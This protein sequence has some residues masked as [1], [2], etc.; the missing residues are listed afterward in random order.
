VAAVFA[1]A[2]ENVNA[3]RL[4]LYASL[5]AVGL[6]VFAY[7][8][9]VLS[10][11][12]AGVVAA[13]TVTAL[14]ARHAP[15]TILA[16]L[17]FM[18]AFWLTCVVAERAG[19]TWLDWGVLAVAGA[20]AFSFRMAALP[21][22]P[23]AGLYVLLR[24]KQE[25]LGFLAVGAV[26]C[27]VAAAIFIGLSSGSALGNEAV[28]SVG[29]VLRDVAQNGRT[30]VEGMQLGVP[31]PLGADAARLPIQALVLGVGGVGALALAFKRPT[32]FGA[33]AAL[34]SVLMV[35]AIPARSARYVWPLFPWIAAGFVH[36]LVVLA[37]ARR[38]ARGERMAWALAAVLLGGSLTLQ[39]LSP[40]P[41]S[42]RNDP[43][44]RDVIATLQREA[45]QDSATRAVFFSPRVL[46]WE[47]RIPAAPLFAAAPDSMFAF[48]AERR[49][50]HVVSGD[51][52][53]EVLYP[54]GIPNLVKGFPE[55]FERVHANSSFEVF[56][57]RAP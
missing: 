24:E 13:W 39:W 30:M 44:F 37:G 55:R 35:L 22:L 21:L 26:W 52:G 14:G 31:I 53:T 45:S 8:R 56:R 40:P 49:I 5:L 43:D 18:A 6:L 27:A 3:A 57:V 4:I 41:V 33:L 1:V 42:V 28:R 15:D 10:P 32:S 51:A 20:L 34:F 23:V 16:D 12:S 17:P 19:K 29:Q 2:G 38:P 9:N 48:L 11:W 36:G 46:T 50:T 54:Q 47:T 7:W 25:R